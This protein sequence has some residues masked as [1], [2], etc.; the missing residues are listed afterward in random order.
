MKKNTIIITLFIFFF[1]YFPT[2]EVL[3]DSVYNLFSEGSLLSDYWPDAP[4]HRVVAFSIALTGIVCTITTWVVRD[5]LLSP[6][7]ED[8]GLIDSI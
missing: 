2:Y 6:K 5:L 4:Y 8:S 1:L 7:Q 3:F